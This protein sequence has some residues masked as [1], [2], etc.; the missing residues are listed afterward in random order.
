MCKKLRIL[1]IED[2][3]LVVSVVQ[4]I[5]ADNFILFSVP[6]IAQAF[7]AVKN[8]PFDLLL[9]D[10]NLLDSTGIQTVI[11]L[12]LTNLPLVILTANDDPETIHQAAELGVEDYVVKH[13]LG[14]A[15][16][17]GKFNFICQKYY[18]KSPLIDFK[19]LEAIKPFFSS[20]K[21]LFK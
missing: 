20:I 15:N 4:H 18:K 16:I 13:D 17:I 1:H 14:R 10:L 21:H 8:H 9:V 2:E 5:C 12:K 3:P 7:E 11:D 19:G 6:S